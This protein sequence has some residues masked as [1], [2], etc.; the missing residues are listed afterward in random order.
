MNLI[1][2]ALNSVGRALA[3]L[4]KNSKLVASDKK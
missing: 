3:W 2:S 1:I 4:K